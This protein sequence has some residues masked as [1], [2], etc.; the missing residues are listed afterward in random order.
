MTT[1]TNHIAREIEARFSTEKF[2]KNDLVNV[3]NSFGK[4]DKSITHVL[5]EMHAR[6]ALR[7][8]GIMKRKGGTQPSKIYARIPS[9]PM[10]STQKKASA[11]E[12]RSRAEMKEA[13][14]N[15]CGIRLHEALDRMTRAVAA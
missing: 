12:N 9:V 10:V 4:N 11:E 8:V 15:E 2:T 1:F 6:G 14:L 7:I 13:Q 3:A 5:R